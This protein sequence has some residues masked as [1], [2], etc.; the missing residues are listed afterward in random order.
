[1]FL[2]SF[3]L[4]ESFYSYHVPWTNC[5]I[6]LTTQPIQQI[7]VLLH[8]Y[9]IPRCVCACELSTELNFIENCQNYLKRGKVLIK[10]KLCNCVAMFWKDQERNV[11]ICIGPHTVLDTGNDW[12]SLTAQDLY[13]DIMLKH[14]V[15]SLSTGETVFVE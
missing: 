12:G 10:K 13:P 7:G 3:L 15:S 9:C 6:S 5:I 8:T 4:I 14:C 1:M 2:P 11:G